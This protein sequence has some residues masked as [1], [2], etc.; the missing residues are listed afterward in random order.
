MKRF[1]SI[2]KW[3]AE[4]A[5]ENTLSQVERQ[6][7]VAGLSRGKPGFC[8][9]FFLEDN[10]APERTLQPTKEEADHS[11]SLPPSRLAS[12]PALYGMD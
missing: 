10:H 4:L 7:V 3:G 6:F 1:T 5:E 12:P 8:T 2:R 11:S 9:L